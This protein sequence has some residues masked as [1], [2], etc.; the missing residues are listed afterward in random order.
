MSTKRQGKKAEIAR[1]AIRPLSVQGVHNVRLSDI[2]ASLGMTG[3]HLLY[4][5]E[6]KNDLFTASMRIVEQDLR[7]RIYAAFETMESG[8]ERWEWLLDTGA[9]TGL[10]DSGLLLWLGA[11]NE[12]VHSED[13]HKLITELESDWQGL[14]RETLRYAIG[15]GELPADLDVDPIVEGV[16]ALLDGLTIRVVIG[17]RPL[18]HDAAMAIVRRFVDPQLPWRNA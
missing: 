12:A 11:W 9:P 6:S 15:R 17:Y 8:R 13:F 4:Y 16:S 1:A 10:D 5:F 3:A 18:D 14:L 7:T 2:G